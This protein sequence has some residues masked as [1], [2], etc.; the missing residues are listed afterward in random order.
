MNACDTGENLRPYDP[1]LLREAVAAG[2]WTP[3]TDDDLEGH[4]QD[5]FDLRAA[6]ALSKVGR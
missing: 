4:M 5:N 3:P 6:V 1:V 2:M